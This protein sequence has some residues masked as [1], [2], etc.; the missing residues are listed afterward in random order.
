MFLCR[1][2][3]MVDK[4]HIPGY[5]DESQPQYVHCSGGMFVLIPENKTTT[6][7]NVDGTHQKPI[8]GSYK[9]YIV[10][11]RGRTSSSIS[12]SPAMEGSDQET[13]IGFL[14]AWNYMLT[15]RWRSNIT[16]DERFQDN[17]LADFRLFC[18]NHDN[19][20]VN[21]W[22]SCWASTFTQ[23]IEADA[24]PVMDTEIIDDNS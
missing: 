19:R 16:G 10:W 4:P 24:V 6:P 2:G 18:C 3:F 13:R 11:Q 7:R 1:F 5:P 22:Q 14:W 23:E 12:E 20:L 17:M 15:R 9:D 21:Y 8:V